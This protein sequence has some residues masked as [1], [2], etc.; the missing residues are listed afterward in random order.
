MSDAGIPEFLWIIG[1]ILAIYLAI[2]TLLM[3][4]FVYR[5]RGETKRITRIL[6]TISFF[7]Q[8]P[9]K[10][11]ANGRM[12]TIKGFDNLVALEE[13]VYEH[14]ESGARFF[15]FASYDKNKGIWMINLDG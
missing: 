8:N 7:I 5:I 6:M 9:P 2:L 14:S 13:G 12:I 1:W 4:F 10:E 3:P 15:G 11:T